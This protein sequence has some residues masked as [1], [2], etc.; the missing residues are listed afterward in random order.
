MEILEYSKLKLGPIK[1]QILVAL[2]K[3]ELNI[4]L[5]TLEIEQYIILKLDSYTFFVEENI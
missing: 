5:T 1:L 2:T 3:L 4:T